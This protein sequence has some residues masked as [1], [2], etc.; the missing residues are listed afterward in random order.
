[1]NTYYDHKLSW[2]L[3]SSKSAA[4]DRISGD[5]TT[6]RDRKSWKSLDLAKKKIRRVCEC[7]ERNPDFKTTM[8]YQQ[9]CINITILLQ[10]LEQTENLVKYN[11]FRGKANHTCI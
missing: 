7:R 9:C 11:L 10:T 6:Q 2:F 3:T 8:A 4:D 1:M 5:F